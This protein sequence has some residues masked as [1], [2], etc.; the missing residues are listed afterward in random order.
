LHA[1]LRLEFGL[2]AAFHFLFVPL[3]IGLLL[4][5]NL[6]QTAHVRTGLAVYR[7]TARFW[8]GLFLLTWL[9]GVCTG[10]PLRWQ[11]MNN[12]GGFAQAASK[13]FAEVF[14]IEGTI[15]PFMLAGVLML[16][17]GKRL[18]GTRL[19]MMVGWLLL[20]LLLVQSH[21]ILSVNAWMQHPVG[22]RFDEGAWRLQSLAAVLL[23]DTALDKL[24]HTLSGAMLAGAL[25]VMAVSASWLLK[26]RH[27]DVAGVGMRTGAWV[28]V[29]G[30]V[31]A[32]LSGHASALGV[33]HH[34]PMKF[35]AF[36]AHWQKGEGAAPLVL[37]ALPDEQAQRN[38]HALEVP[39]LLSFLGGSSL[40]ASPPGITDLT[41][42][43]ARRLAEVLAHPGASRLIE[44]DVADQGLL[45]LYAATQA[46][47]ADEWA[48]WSVQTRVDEVARAMQ[49]PVAGTFWAFRLM[50][51][52][53]LALMLLCG[54][55]FWHRHTVA[56]GRHRWLLQALRWGLPLP[57]VAILSGWAVAELGRQ[58]WTVQ[59]HLPTYQAMLAP[60]LELAVG[61]AFVLCAGA[62]LV[63]L[64]YVLAW[65]A[66]LRNGPDRRWRRRAMAGWSGNTSVMGA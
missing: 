37:L 6:L 59:G 52:S 16:A 28:G 49:P 44:Q 27:V 41:Q 62:V 57:W 13:V 43:H 66:M 20:G 24:W 63:A 46:R 18:L 42:A 11:V 47:H 1:F 19:H 10:Y 64:A 25:C 21:T 38:R 30:I 54:C 39:Y 65:R 9:A 5:V 2:S 33:A 29:L 34:Q 14:V 40:L 58:P 56:L 7:R 15:G 60:P 23:N 55:A 31:S 8:R 61:M 36:E 3:S 12:W 51:A 53:G 48:S 22:V 35:A 17:L 32:L 45:A 26:G 50:V 4:C